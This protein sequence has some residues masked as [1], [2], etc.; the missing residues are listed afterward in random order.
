MKGIWQESLKTLPMYI[1]RKTC[2]FDGKI[3]PYRLHS[4]KHAS[5]LTP[6]CYILTLKRGSILELETFRSQ[7]VEDSYCIFIVWYHI[8]CSGI[9]NFFFNFSVFLGEGGILFC[10]AL[11]FVFCRGFLCVFFFVTQFNNKIGFLKVIA[12]KPNSMFYFQ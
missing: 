5:I 1:W 6:F 10:F 8:K 9:C 2:L 7:W 12:N 11:G 3:K 4:Y